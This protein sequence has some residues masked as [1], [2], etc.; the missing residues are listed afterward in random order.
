MSR[1][2][3]DDTLQAWADG[4]LDQARAAEVETF[5]RAHPERAALAQGWRE[6]AARLRAALAA[7]L[8]PAPALAPQA[9]RRRLA[10][11][12]RARLGVAASL[13]LAAGMGALGGW[14][15]HDVREQ[16]ARPP[17][18]DA[19]AAYRL[20]AEG[21][22]APLA[23][24]ADTPALQA[25]L[26]RH[27]GSAG[28]IPDLAS[29]GYRLAG[30]RLLSTPEGAAAMLVYEG[31]GGTPIALY[32][33]PRSGRMPAAG[34]RRDGRLLAQ[35]WAEGAT[36]FALVGPATEAALHRLAPLL[37]AAG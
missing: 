28:Q 22:D 9:V 16:A 3:D 23:L 14:R 19:V 1:E 27:F 5:L 24:E 13:L 11:R 31:A 20:F 30:G 29:Q 36:A 15:L 35:Y 8:P 2:I 21:G 17:M 6:D 25:F 12:R 18:A 34:E 32:L 26:R 7:P 10:E 4:Q 37:R 33:R